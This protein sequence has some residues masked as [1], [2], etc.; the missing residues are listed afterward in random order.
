MLGAGLRNQ[1]HRNAS[2]LERRKQAIGRAR[3]TDHAGALEIDERHA[4]DRSNA[5]DVVRHLGVW[6]DPAAR[7]RGLWL[8]RMQTGMSLLMA[9]PIVCGWMTSV[10]KYASSIAS[11]YDSLLN[12]LCFGN[13]VRIRAHD[14][15]HV[16]PDREFSRF[17]SAAKIA[18]E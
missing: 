18:A 13:A 2:L 1:R 7:M 11:L 17:A 16:T 10:P 6:T 9:G 15:V 3:H 8:L 4:A 14:A 12:D 5:L